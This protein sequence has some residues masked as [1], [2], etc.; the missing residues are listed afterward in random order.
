MNIDQQTL[1]GLIESGRRMFWCGSDAERIALF[2]A[3]D[4]LGYKW[5]SGENLLDSYHGPDANAEGVRITV[6]EYTDQNKSCITYGSGFRG[7]ETRVADLVIR[8]PAVDPSALLSL[9]ME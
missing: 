5:N 7:V 9:L 1:A 4:D 2:T 3:L 6:W 8:A